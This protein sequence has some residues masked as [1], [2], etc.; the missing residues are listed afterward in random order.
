M[1]AKTWEK[2]LYKDE[3]TGAIQVAIDPNNTNIVYA[4]LWAG[5]LGP[6]ENGAWNGK[7]SGLFKSTDGGNTWKKLG[8]GLPSTEQ[9]LGR[10]GFCIA[11]SNSNRLYAT[12]DAGK[13]GGIY[14]S[15]DAGEHWININADERLWGRG[16]DFAEIK[17]RPQ[18]CRYCI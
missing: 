17:S 15:D 10:I 13:Y 16:S 14:R 12:V 7:E 1:E 18:Q 5:R 11:A 2:V 6:W 9:G 8:G 3:N 4:D